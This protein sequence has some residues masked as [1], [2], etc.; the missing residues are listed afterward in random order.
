MNFTVKQNRWYEA[1]LSLNFI[2]KRASNSQIIARLA[3]AGFDKCRCEG[4]GKS[5]TVQ[6]LWSRADRTGELPRQIESIKEVFK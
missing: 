1:K 5:R 4:R 2:E 6:A 3:A